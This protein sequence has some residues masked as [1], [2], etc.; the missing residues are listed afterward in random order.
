MI[1]HDS[2]PLNKKQTLFSLYNMLKVN[3]CK[4]LFQVIIC[5]TF[6]PHVTNRVWVSNLISQCAD[7]H[8]WPETT[9][10]QRHNQSEIITKRG[11]TSYY[12]L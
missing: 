10:K 6:A 7:G 4:D 12:T 9:Q 11:T 5:E 2:F 8:V 3:N 1:F